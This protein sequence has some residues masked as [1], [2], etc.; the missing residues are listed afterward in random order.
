MLSLNALPSLQSF[1]QPLWTS[2]Y[3][4]CNI[5]TDT[6]PYAPIIIRLAPELLGFPLI[7]PTDANAHCRRRLHL[8]PHVI[9]P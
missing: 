1:V 9:V 6:I 7:F 8:L 4:I 3:L 2:P 5:P